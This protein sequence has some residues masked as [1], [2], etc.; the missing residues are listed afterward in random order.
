MNASTTRKTPLTIAPE[1]P[2]KAPKAKHPK[3]AKAKV[4]TPDPLAGSPP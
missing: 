4:P 2:A 3:A 1:A